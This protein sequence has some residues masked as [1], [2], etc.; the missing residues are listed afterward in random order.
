MDDLAIEL[1]EIAIGVA[2]AVARERWGA[3]G[4]S[5]RSF[6]HI[7]TVRKTHVSTEIGGGSGLS[8]LSHPLPMTTLGAVIRSGHPQSRAVRC[9]ESEVRT[10]VRWFWT[11]SEEMKIGGQSRV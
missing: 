4:L 3:A 9:L 6:S 5:E 1:F 11:A 7:H 10:G 8:R 2:G